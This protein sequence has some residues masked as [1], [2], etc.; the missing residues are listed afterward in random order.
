MRFKEL[1]PMARTMLASTRSVVGRDE[2]IAVEAD[3]KKVPYRGV[4]IRCEMM[5]RETG[6]APVAVEGSMGIES[7]I[8]ESRSRS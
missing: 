5:S 6:P 3:G 7:S 1:N 4:G 8:S 2:A